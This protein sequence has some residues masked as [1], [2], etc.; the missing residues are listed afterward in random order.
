MLVTLV[1][2]YLNKQEG[3]GNI[4]L[5]VAVPESLTRKH[6]LSALIKRSLLSEDMMESS[7]VTAN[8]RNYYFDLLLSE[9]IE[10]YYDEEQ[11]E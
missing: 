6:I 11:I 9:D 2:P 7:I 1:H 4:T 5:S 10:L 3:P 8:P